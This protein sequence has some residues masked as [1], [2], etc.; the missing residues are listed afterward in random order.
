MHENFREIR[1]YKLLEFS[2]LLLFISNQQSWLV[3]TVLFL[4]LSLPKSDA[5]QEATL[6]GEM[7]TSFAFTVKEPT[8]SEVWK[9]ISHILGFYY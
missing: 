1:S 8:E 9:K 7:A 4:Y 6:L 2:E 3:V 5:K